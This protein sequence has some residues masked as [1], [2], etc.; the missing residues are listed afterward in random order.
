MKIVIVGLGKHGRTICEKLA[1]DEE[2]DII[3]IDSDPSE[4]DNCVNQFDVMG[5]CG[6]GA[7]IETLKGAGGA[8]SDVLIACTGSDELNIL[9]CLVAKKIGIKR[10]IC[11]IKDSE[12]SKQI[13][14]MREELNISYTFNPYDDTAKEIIRDIRFPSAIKRDVMANNKVDIVE[15]KIDKNSPLKNRNLSEIKESIKINFLIAA[16]ERDGATFIPKGNVTVLEN[17]LVYLIASGK[18]LGV[19]FRKISSFKEKIKTAFIIGGGKVSYFVAK[20]FIDSGVAVKILENSSEKCKLLANTL[21]EAIVI[22]GDANNQK[23]ML[24]EGIANSDCVISVTASDETNIIASCFAKN[25]GVRK[26]I[27]KVNNNNYDVILANAGL[28]TIVSPQDIFTENV[29]R[30]IKGMETSRKNNLQFKSMHSIVGDDVVAYEF[31]ISKEGDYLN[32]PLKDL[33]IKKDVLIAAILRNNKITIPSGMD[34]LE[35]NDIVIFVSNTDI[36]DIEDIWDK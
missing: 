4:V 25:L 12:Y 10:T 11:R 19:A 9:V 32:K 17:D 21:P 2:N 5:Y 6:N 14:T 34:V 7:L 28:D 3:A 15:L 30:A 18:D 33:N 31:V 13:S 22:K 35:I 16:I 36:S 23:V 20:S 27:T 8:K 24:A 26:I 1:S 29:S